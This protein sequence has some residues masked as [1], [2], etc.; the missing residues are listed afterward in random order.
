MNLSDSSDRAKVPW[1][2]QGASNN[3]QQPSELPEPKR[4]LVGR[5]NETNYDL[6]A[7]P[8]R[9]DAGTDRKDSI[10]G[11]DAGKESL[12][13]ESTIRDPTSTTSMTREI[14]LNI[15]PRHL[16]MP[17]ESENDQS[18]SADYAVLTKLGEGGMGEVWLAKQKSLGR[19]IALKQIRSVDLRQMSPDQAQSA[20]ESFLT[21]AV[22]TG[23]LNH[24]NIVPV[25]DMGT[26]VDGN[27][28]YSMKCV[29]GVSWDKLIDTISEAENIEILRKVADAIGFAHS[30]GVVH[31]D[32]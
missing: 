19:E 20:R 13:E 1:S 9:R 11:D 27:L 12:K 22:V 8:L 24:P 7:S 2:R 14:Q 5:D 10:T 16:S 25:Y 29:R 23:E 32:L 18:A 26:D 3:A 30:R 15:Q 21:E 31:R 6:E 4:T 28:L 17:G